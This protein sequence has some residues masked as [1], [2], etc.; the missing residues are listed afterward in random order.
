MLTGELN[1][2]EDFRYQMERVNELRTRLMEFTRKRLAEKYDSA[3][4]A[5]ESIP[6]YLLGEYN[7]IFFFCQ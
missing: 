4:F 6:A 2:Y 1:A 3:L 5:N 7:D